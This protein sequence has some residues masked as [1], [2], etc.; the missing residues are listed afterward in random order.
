MRSTVVGCVPN[1]NDVQSHGSGS[2]MARLPAYGDLLEARDPGIR[3]R[4][5]E[6]GAPE[7]FTDA[8]A[9]IVA[10]G[11]EPRIAALRDPQGARFTVSAFAG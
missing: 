4:H 1:R 9:W 8:V 10:A 7:G 11:G 5:A 6:Y 2:L 3:R